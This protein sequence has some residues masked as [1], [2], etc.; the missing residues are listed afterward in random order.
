[1]NRKILLILIIS[2]A[3]ILAV[4][5]GIYLSVFNSSL[6]LNQTD[7]GSSGSYFAGTIGICFSLLGIILIYLTFFEQRKQQFENTFQQYISNYYSLLKTIKERWL[8]K[9]SDSNGNPIYQTGREIFGNA[10][11]FIEIDNAEETFIKIFNIHNNVF[12]NYCSYL[13]EFFKIIDN[14]NEL[15]NKTKT[16]Y[17]DRFL[18]MLSTYELIFFAYYIK[19]LYATENYKEIKYHVQNKLNNLQLTNDAPHKRKIDFIINELK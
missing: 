9:E 2:I 4:F 19:Y 14:N 15:T 6:S 16:I 12:Q 17:I 5:A 11:R 10:V 1:M 13:V 8:H 3:V 7:W 18:P